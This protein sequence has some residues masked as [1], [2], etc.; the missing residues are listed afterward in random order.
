MELI[1]AKQV[2]RVYNKNMD[3]GQIFGS[4]YFAAKNDL[5]DNRRLSPD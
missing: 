4:L 1:I 2:K 5:A 3:F